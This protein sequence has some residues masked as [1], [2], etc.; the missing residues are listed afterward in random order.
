MFKYQRANE[1]ER[2]VSTSYKITGLD[3]DMDYEF[4]VAAENRG[5]I[6]AYSETSSQVRTIQPEGRCNS[7]MFCQMVYFDKV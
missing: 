4:R 7:Y 3:K 2:V 1:G 5:G 6:G